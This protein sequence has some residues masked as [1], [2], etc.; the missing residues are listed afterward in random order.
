MKSFGALKALMEKGECYMREYCNSYI[1]SNLKQRAV[2][3]SKSLADIS[4]K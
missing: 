4:T 1:E 3:G 2:L